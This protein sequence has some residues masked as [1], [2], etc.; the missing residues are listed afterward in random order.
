MITLLLLRIAFN[1]SRWTTPDD[2]GEWAAACSLAD[3]ADVAGRIDKFVF[4]RDAKLALAGQLLIRAALRQ[5]AAAELGLLTPAELSARLRRTPTGKPYL[6]AAADSSIA[7]PEV[8]FNSSHHGD[9]VAVVAA[10]APN[11]M[12]GVDVMRIDAPPARES[13]DSYIGVMK[14]AFHPDEFRYIQSQPSHEIAEKSNRLHAFYRFWTLKECY[15]KAIGAGLGMELSQIR[16]TEDASI[17]LDLRI[18]QITSN[19]TCAVDNIP[20]DRWHFEQQYLDE[21]HPIAVA[22]HAPNG[23]FTSGRFSILPSFS[24]LLTLAGGTT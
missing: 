3:P 16:L 18:Q 14:T 8:H 23:G 5:I 17:P 20:L 1:V 22:M 4:K 11:C 2:D 13:I 7:H 21:L 12:V 15:V 24:S 19:V 6:T 9:Y 10:V